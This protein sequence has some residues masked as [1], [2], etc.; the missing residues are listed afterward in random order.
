MK[1]IN[2]L[3]HNPNLVL[4]LGFFDGIHIAHQKI[5][6]QA[7]EL[8]K[9]NTLKSALIT[10]KEH[11]L[12]ELKNYKIDYLYNNKEKCQMIQD[13]GIDYVYMLDFKDYKDLNADEYIKILH[14]NFNP[15]FIVT[16][17][18]H[19]FGKNQTG[20]QQ[21]LEENQKKYNYIYKKIEPMCYKNELISTT[22]IKDKLSKGEIPIA[23]KLLG[24]NYKITNE[25]IKGQQL[26]RK[27]G[28]PTV[29][30]E[31]Q[32]NIFK[33][34]YGIYKGK[35]FDKKALINW[36]VRPT[37]DGKKE[38]LEAHILDFNKNIYGQKIDVFFEEKIRDEKKFNSLD[39]LKH[40]ITLDI[41]SIQ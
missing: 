34:P 24:R 8:A 26:G 12:V 14:E 10:F 33:L 2:K 19:T 15:K 7:V 4:A 30:L 40:Q 21:F 11:P 32:E 17:F 31:W 29:N 6:K 41:K 1:N 5:I 16:G 27:L 23:N 3:Q 36:G 9:E 25:V 20:N 38:I 37:V 35:V 22:N 28:F 13:L 39:A 18:N